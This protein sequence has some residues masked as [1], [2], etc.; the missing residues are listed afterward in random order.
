MHMSARHPFRNLSLKNLLIAFL[1]ISLMLMLLLISFFFGMY[2]QS[3]ESSTAQSLTLYS[4]EQAKLIN[5][6]LTHIRTSLYSLAS[7]RE[8]VDYLAGGQAYRVA[9]TAYVQAVITDLPRYVSPID[10]IIVTDSKG[11]TALMSLNKSDMYNFML[12]N[13]ILENYHAEKDRGTW[14]FTPSCDQPGQ[15]LM[16]VAVPIFNTGASMQWENEAGSV[17]AFSTAQSLLENFSFFQKPFAIYKEGTLLCTNSPA[18]RETP[19][20]PPEDWLRVG[21][22]TLKWDIYMEPPLRSAESIFS[23]R[24]LRWNIITILV[25]IAVE[26]GLILAI[27]R[28]IIAP[29]SSIS[30]Q[31]TR[32]NS[33]AS[34]IDNPAPARS[35]LNTLVRNINAM[36]VRTNQLTQEVSA[37]KMRL[38]EMD[39][40][41]LKEK[42]MFLQAQINPHFLYNML[43]CICGMAA[44]EGNTQIREMT[45]LLS[46][47]Y[48]Y[49]LKSPES[50]LG[51]EVE[52]LDLYQEIIRR[53]YRESYRFDIQIPEDLA[54]LPMPRMVL[55]PLVENAV[56]HGFPRGSGQ[57][58]FVRV[59][60]E[61]NENIL[62]L[63]I[64]DNGCGM[65]REKLKEIN[66]RLAAPDFQGADEGRHIGIFN[67]STRLRLVYGENS[68][69][70]LET[71]S[72]G[73]L[74]V[75]M[76]IHYPLFDAE[77]ETAEP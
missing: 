58:F 34:L 8:I 9:N 68:G 21:I 65:A 66:D 43:E 73:G 14:F 50:T 24:A 62:V 32:I 33:T 70:M 46:R 71:N 39:I 75:R 42:N 55:E 48:R 23:D 54:L 30:L 25:F 13:E 3:L 60:A 15:F 53:R 44:E 4:D 31:S 20:G 12:R 29:I 41:R 74:T 61:L 76:T 64:E 17:I 47:M 6:T 77:E 63:C 5:D 72:W 18:L 35:E 40:L 11:K 27:H 22:Q 38:M 26:C 67:V 7:K 69:L 10:D 16:A 37:A 49:C 19:A 57:N 56:Q 1:L 52:C 2:R 28:T 45:H 51:E 36:T 59:L